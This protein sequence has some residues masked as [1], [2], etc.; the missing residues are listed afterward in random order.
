MLSVYNLHKVYGK[1]KLAV[2]ALKGIN[3]NFP[4]TGMVVILGK[5]GCG[6]S[7]LM[8]ILGGLDRPTNGN[9]YINGTP[10]SSLSERRLDDY[11]N[12]Y[13]GFVFQ[14]FNIIETKTGYENI[15]RAVKKTMLKRLGKE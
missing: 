4:E 14:N 3:I 13:V 10:F 12:T 5:S 9:V 11:R 1:G 6:K 7:T 2:H 8:N 15:V